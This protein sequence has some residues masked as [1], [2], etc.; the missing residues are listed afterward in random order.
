MIISEVSKKYNIPPNTI[1][2]YERI[3]LLPH[4]ARNKSGIRDYNETD[5]GWIEYIKYMRDAGITIKVLLKYVELFQKGEETFEERFK[6]VSEQRQMLQQKIGI[7]Q[8]TLGRLDNKL[9]WLKE[10]HLRNK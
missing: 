2:Y 10:E 3:G 7:L 8:K 9:E 1:R 6:L 5:C 4:I